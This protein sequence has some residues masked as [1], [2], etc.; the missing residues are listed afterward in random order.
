MRIPKDIQRIKD[1]VQQEKITQ[2]SMDEGSNVFVYETICP[3][4]GKP[5]LMR[6]PFADWTYFPVSWSEEL[7]TRNQKAQELLNKYEIPVEIDQNMLSDFGMQ[8]NTCLCHLDQPIRLAFGDRA[9]VDKLFISEEGQMT[10]VFEAEGTAYKGQ[11]DCIEQHNAGDILIYHRNPRRRSDK[12]CIEIYDAK[13][14]NLGNVPAELSEYI[15]PLI[16]EGKVKISGSI[17]GIETRAQRGSKA[18]KAKLYCFINISPTDQ[19]NP[20]KWLLDSRIKYLKDKKSFIE[21]GGHCKLRYLSKKQVSPSDFTTLNYMVE[22][23]LQCSEMGDPMYAIESLKV[24]EAVQVKPTGSLTNGDFSFA[25]TDQVGN[26]I[27]RFAMAFV[28]AIAPLVEFGGL[29]I[30]NPVY[31]GKVCD[32]KTFHS[33][34]EIPCLRFAMVIPRFYSYSHEQ[35][36]C[37]V[38]RLQ[39]ILS[40]ITGNPSEELKKLIVYIKG[41]ELD[42]TCD[43]ALNCD[44][45]LWAVVTKDTGKSYLLEEDFGFNCDDDHGFF[46]LFKQVPDDDPVRILDQN[47]I[48]IGRLENF[49]V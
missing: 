13:E 45:I 30:E 28:A 10:F 2:A 12:Q 46:Y 36:S 8:H 19:K 33:H 11:T 20:M 26:R 22:I 29:T 16:D 25:I 6:E 4:C 7:S 21:I 40:S 23:F 27:G 34:R 24:G 31:I 39:E 43:L 42:Y 41:N 47:G 48:L 1:F 35:I 5:K 14:S 3:D 44:G 32:N 17:Y 38:A 9:N 15:S 18:K 49:G 37:E